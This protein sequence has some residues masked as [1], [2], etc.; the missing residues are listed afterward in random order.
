M[1]LCVLIHPFWM[2]CLTCCISRHDK[3]YISVH[4]VEVWIASESKTH[5]NY[6][7]DTRL[8]L[9]QMF[10]YLLVSCNILYV[11]KLQ[12]WVQMLVWTK[13]KQKNND[14][15]AAIFPAAL[16]NSLSREIPVSLWIRPKK[17]IRRSTTRKYVTECYYPVGSA[18]T[19]VRPWGESYLRG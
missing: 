15:V 8:I 10:Y 13:N 9:I 1:L 3:A 11:C 6:C 14:V 2:S 7:S 19:K 18:S 5:S 12:S 17:G 16:L 4:S